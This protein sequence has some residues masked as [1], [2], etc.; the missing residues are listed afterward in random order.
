[1]KKLFPIVL[2]LA[3]F[4]SCS[5]ANNNKKK[6]IDTLNISAAISGYKENS[7]V[8]LIDASSQKIIDSTIISNNRFRITKKIENEPKMLLLQ[9]ENNVLFLFVGN[10]NIQIKGNKEGFSKNIKITGSENQI[11]KDKLDSL[12][13]PYNKKR[14]EYLQKMFELR[15]KNKWSDKLQTEY[16]GKN[17]LITTIDNKI[18]SLS[19]IFY[20][21][22]INT[23]YVLYELVLNKSL[24]SKNELKKLLNKLDDKFTNNKYVKVLKS[25]VKYPTIEEGK[26][27][28]DF[29]AINNKNDTI[30]ISNLIRKNDYNLLEFS[31][32]YCSW[33]KK[34]LPTIKRISNIDNVNV[35]T[36]YV[37]NSKD[38]IN[39]SKK[40][41]INWTKLWDKNGRLSE[42]YTKYNIYATP[43]YF[44]INK[45]GKIVKIWNGYNQN[46]ENEILK[47]IKKAV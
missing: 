37:D 20:K 34:A 6:K 45:N 22:N 38:W 15:N 13:F 18:D 30:K 39:Y 16:W 27:F 42:A 19:K 21:D 35:I 11:V 25:Y 1:M 31:S 43:T 2:L 44:L 12:L 4:F 26:S 14:N 17:G 10:E 5:K 46:L 29:K 8:K 41:G 36:F 9:I 33:C 3:T 47:I 32:I 23:N 40:N 28:V 7:K 24:Y